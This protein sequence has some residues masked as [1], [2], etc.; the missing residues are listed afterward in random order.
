MEHLGDAV[1][2]CRER[3]GEHSGAIHGRVDLLAIGADEPFDIDEHGVESG[4]RS[5]HL[6]AV[7]VQ[8]IRHRGKPVVEG[9]DLVAARR[10]R[11]DEYLQVAQRAEEV[12]TAVRDGAHRCRQFPQRFA[13]RG[14]VPL[15]IVG[16]DVEHLTERPPRIVVGRTEFGGQASQ[17]GGDLVP[18]DGYRCAVERDA[19][20]GSE[21]GSAGVGRSDLEESGRDQCRRHEG[22]LCGGWDA[23]GGVDGECHPHPVAA[24]FDPGDPSDLDPHDA[25]IVTDV[26]A[27]SGRE[28][29][30][31][32]VRRTP[33]HDGERHDGD[34]HQDEQRHHPRQEPCAP[35]HGVPP[36][37]VI[38]ASSRARVRAGSMICIGSRFWM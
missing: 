22:G 2:L 25:H 15:G 37:T 20:A 11:V 23:V 30:R 16:S 3:L 10:Q 5:A 27:S 28:L 17:L 32:L 29:R 8:D 4:Q 36:G 31:V 33:G 35:L 18:F 34:H 9:H 19:R 26:Q 21:F 24:R 14:A 6:V 13:D 1:T 38:P 7:R 12:A